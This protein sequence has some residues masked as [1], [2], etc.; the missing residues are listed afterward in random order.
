MNKIQD[1]G[2][3]FKQ[4]L[5]SAVRD[6][7]GERRK[8]AKGKKKKREEKKNLIT[9]TDGGPIRRKCQKAARDSRSTC[10]KE[11]RSAAERGGSADGCV[12]REMME[13]PSQMSQYHLIS[14]DKI[15]CVRRAAALPHL[16]RFCFIFFWIFWLF[17]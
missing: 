8:G 12:S 7:R 16:F 5:S 17:L 1:V 2:P 11:K 13:S 3:H 10:E 4:F 9:P 6:G 14:G 15:I